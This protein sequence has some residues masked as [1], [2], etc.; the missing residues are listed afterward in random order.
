MEVIYF[1]EMVVTSYR[2][3]DAKQETT[4]CIFSDMKTSTQEFSISH[5][6]RIPQY[7]VLVF[8][9]LFVNK[10]CGT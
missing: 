9:K 8:I 2:L 3:H 1:S 5:L 10:N 4:I 7:Y 6:L